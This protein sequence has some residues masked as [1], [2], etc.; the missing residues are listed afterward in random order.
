MHVNISR[1]M[2]EQE[3]GAL[4]LLRRQ[5]VEAANGASQAFAPKTVDSLKANALFQR[6]K[7]IAR[8]WKITGVAKMFAIRTE[9]AFAAS[10]VTR[11]IKLFLQQHQKL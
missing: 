10:I 9:K 4:T 5:H 3:C 8:T 2:E 1:I 7:S 11:T 6:I